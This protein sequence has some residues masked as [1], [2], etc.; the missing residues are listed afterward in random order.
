MRAPSLTE[1]VRECLLADFGGE[2]VE[3]LCAKLR[4]P[5][6]GRRADYL[7]ND[8]SMVI[9]MERFVNDRTEKLACAIRIL[10]EVPEPLATRP[11]PELALA[12]LHQA[13]EIVRKAHK[14][15]EDGL[16]DYIRKADKQI[17]GTKAALELPDSKGVL[18]IANEGAVGALAT[19]IQ[20]A[21][22]NLLRRTSKVERRFSDLDA[23]IVIDGVRRYQLTAT[24]NLP[25]ITVATAEAITVPEFQRRP[26]S[27]IPMALYRFYGH[28]LEYRLPTTPRLL[29]TFKEKGPLMRFNRE[30]I[31][32]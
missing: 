19:V 3:A 21:L 30:P 32:S 23:I 7:I 5:Y 27:R 6:H 11:D 13:A 22:I 10:Q 20:P 26:E 2:C 1:V 15:T 24:K 14:A 25:T 31:M 12:R 17:R 4:P 9:E 29:A 28:A 18:I 16:Y 8:R